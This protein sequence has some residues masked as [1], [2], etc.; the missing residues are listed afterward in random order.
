[1]KNH[2]IIAAAL[3]LCI[4]CSQKVPTPQ[5][6]REMWV[7]YMLKVAD[8]VLKNTAEGTL[9]VNMPYEA[10]PGKDTR[11]FSYLEAFGRTICGVAPWIE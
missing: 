3:L 1:M 9:K 8:P 7:E 5:Q 6:D 4:G 11:P 2:L 10:H